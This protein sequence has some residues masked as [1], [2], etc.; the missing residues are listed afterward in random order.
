MGYG[1]Y[2][3]VKKNNELENK[4]QKL[5]DKMYD[6]DMEN[7]RSLELISKTIEKIESNGAVDTREIKEHITEQTKNIRDDISR[8]K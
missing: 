6:R 1:L 8:I 2:F 5:V 4:N 7:I 3:L